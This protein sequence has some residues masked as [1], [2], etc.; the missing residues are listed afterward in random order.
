MNILQNLHSL[1]SHHICIMVATRTL[2]Y[3]WPWPSSSRPWPWTSRSQH[4]VS[5]ITLQWFKLNS[6]Y[7]HQIFIMVGA[8]TLFL[9]DDLDLGWSSRSWPWPPGEGFFMHC[10]YIL[11]SCWKINSID[12]FGDFTSY[13]ARKMKF[14]VMT[15]IAVVQ[16][17]WRYIFAGQDDYFVDRV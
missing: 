11:F 5:S 8:S 15:M 17:L 2:Y 7:L 3:G 10:M 6:P 13:G 4:L 12:N 16:V 14:V 1:Y 9:M